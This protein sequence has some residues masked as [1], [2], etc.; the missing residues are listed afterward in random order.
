MTLQP[1]EEVWRERAEEAMRRLQAWVPGMPRNG[2]PRPIR[3]ALGAVKGTLELVSG[4]KDGARL[5]GE[6]T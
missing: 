1:L 5:A 4:S 3:V 6:D 2:G